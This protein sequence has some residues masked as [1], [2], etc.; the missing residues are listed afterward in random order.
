MTEKEMLGQYAE[1]RR[2]HAELSEQTKAAKE[3][4]D[5]AEHNLVQML[6]DKDATSTAKY[7]GLGY[8][9]LAAPA[10]YASYNKE[11]EDLVFDFLR[12]NGMEAIIKPS[13]HHKSLSS[14]VKSKLESGESIPEFITKYTVQGVRYYGK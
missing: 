3:E 4:L 5:T 7:D 14:F 6:L 10:L 13:V 11:N 8:V 12:Q 2:R 9:S 1:A